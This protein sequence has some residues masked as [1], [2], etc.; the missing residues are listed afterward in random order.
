[1]WERYDH[2]RLFVS[3][4]FT[5]WRWYFPKRMWINQLFFFQ[6]RASSLLE[7][8]IKH[9]NEQEVSCNTLVLLVSHHYRETHSITYYHSLFLLFIFLKYQSIPCHIVCNIYVIYMISIIIH[10][11]LVFDWK[12]IIFLY[13]HV[14]L[15][16]ILTLIF[17]M[18]VHCQV[19]LSFTPHVTCPSVWS[20]KT[21]TSDLTFGWMV[22][23][24]LRFHVIRLFFSYLK[25][26]TSWPWSWSLT[27][28]GYQCFRIT[29]CLWNL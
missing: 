7:M 22:I 20:T 10:I 27:V 2:F 19:G 24:L 16:L 28:W 5:W 13:L 25:C 4:K 11:D 9:A 26:L 21:L 18:I 8:Y 1:M 15:F 29:S 23:E 14:L 17:N 3:I 12:F 6:N